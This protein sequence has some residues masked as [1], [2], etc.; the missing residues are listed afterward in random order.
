MNLLRET[1][2]AGGLQSVDNLSTAHAVFEAERGCPSVG[3]PDVLCV[4]MV[5]KA[6]V[7][8]SPATPG[9]ERG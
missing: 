5:S 8:R 2:F 7:N 1:P 4:A 9:C 6:A 3:T